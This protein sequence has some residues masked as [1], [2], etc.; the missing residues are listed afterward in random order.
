MVRT[1]C[2]KLRG[3]WRSRWRQCQGQL[4]GFFYKNG[5]IMGHFPKTGERLQNL[6]S[7]RGMCDNQS[8]RETLKEAVGYLDLKRRRKI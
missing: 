4:P 8:H 1:Y 6:L 2:A 7:L 3:K 5:C